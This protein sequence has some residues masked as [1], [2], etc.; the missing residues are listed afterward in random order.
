[1]TPADVSLALVGYEFVNGLN[2]VYTSTALYQC[3]EQD[4]M[5]HSGPS[6]KQLSTVGTVIWSCVAVQ[7][8]FML[9]QVA[10]SF[11]SSVTYVTFVPFDFVVDSH[12]TS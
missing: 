10:G 4:D 2:S 7:T 8:T 9:L 3:E 5:C 12:V 11:R 6:C 1:V